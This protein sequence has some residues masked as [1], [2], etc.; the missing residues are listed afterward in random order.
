MATRYDVIQQREIGG[1]NA[2][3][4]LSQYEIEAADIL[5]SL[6]GGAPVDAVRSRRP[7]YTPSDEAV[8]ITQGHTLAHLRPPMLNTRRPALL[9]PLSP[10]LSLP[11]P[12][13][14][15]SPVYDPPPSPVYDPPP[16]DDAPPMDEPPAA[17]GQKRPKGSR[18]GYK[19]FVKKMRPVVKASLPPATSKFAQNQ[20]IMKEVGRRWQALTDTQKEG[21]KRAVGHRQPPERPPRTSQK[22]KTDPLDK[23]NVTV[24]ELRRRV[25]EGNEVYRGNKVKMRKVLKVSSKAALRRASSRLKKM[26]RGVPGHWNTDKPLS[27]LIQSFNKM[28]KGCA[29]IDDAHPTFL[30]TNKDRERWQQ[31]MEDRAESQLFTL[32]PN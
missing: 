7:R 22:M 27:S 9:P 10:L 20:E 12:V 32:P 18:S 16:M 17:T 23:D 15:P 14:P 29:L 11:S 19:Y 31:T 6:Q 13:P 2:P 26:F 24:S 5:S 4:T 21:W 28:Q 30:L 1:R 25:K 8:A 3:E